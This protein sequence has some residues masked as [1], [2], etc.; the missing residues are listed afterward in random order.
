MASRTPTHVQ[1]AITGTR[2]ALRE[3]NSFQAFNPDNFPV[4]AAIRAGIKATADFFLR[5]D[6][7]TRG[8]LT[9]EEL[10]SVLSHLRSLARDRR[11]ILQ[12][13]CR[14]GKAIRVSLPDLAQ[15]RLRYTVDDFRAG[16]SFHDY[17]RHVKVWVRGELAGDECVNLPKE[18]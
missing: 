7:H 6:E 17:I 2:N 5:V 11:I 10:I 14:R 3:A 9:D 13:A 8:A 12:D 16:R 18:I 15:L 4:M 1:E